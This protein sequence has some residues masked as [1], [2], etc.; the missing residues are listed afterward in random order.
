MFDVDCPG[1]EARVL[2]GPRNITAMDNTDAGIVVRW[3]CRCG[4]EGSFLTGRPCDNPA[5]P[6]DR[7]T[8]A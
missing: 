5:W 2:L 3:R 1:C 7:S 6:E 4:S 8:A